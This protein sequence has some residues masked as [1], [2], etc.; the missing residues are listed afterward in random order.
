MND[1]IVKV[2]LDGKEYTFDTGS[3]AFIFHT[4]INNDIHN[5]YS[6]KELLDYVNYVYRC[7]IDDDNPTPLGA[8]A[9]YIAENWENVKRLGYRNIT[10]LYYSQAI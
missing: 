2:I 6:M 10:E 5:N 9:D 8:L 4:G 3:K 7:Y 1:I